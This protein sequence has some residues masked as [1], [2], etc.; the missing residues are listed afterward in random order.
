HELGRGPSGR[1]S[2]GRTL[3]TCGSLTGASYNQCALAGRIR[4]ERPSGLN[5]TSS[6]TPV[7]FGALGTATATGLSFGNVLEGERNGRESLRSDT[8]SSS[9]LCLG[10]RPDSDCSGVDN[11]RLLPDG[12]G[13]GQGQDRPRVACRP[14]IPLAGPPGA[15]RHGDSGQFPYR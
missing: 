11:R 10:S 13:L 14:R 7:M 2:T 12:R 6:V 3:R 9:L 1:G 8:S 4:P 5:L 15:R